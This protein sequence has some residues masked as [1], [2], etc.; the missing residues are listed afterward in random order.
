MNEIKS[1]KQNAVAVKKANR[2]YDIHSQGAFQ[3]KRNRDYGR[4]N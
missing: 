1:E 3:R 2:Q 4:K